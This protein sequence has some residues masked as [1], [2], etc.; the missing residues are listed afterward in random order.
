MLFLTLEDETG[1]V[2]AAAA[3]QTLERFKRELGRAPALVVRGRV[4]REGSAVSLLVL[5]ATE[6]R[7]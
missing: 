7:V 2:N 4:E 3:P 6:L 1:L 5:G